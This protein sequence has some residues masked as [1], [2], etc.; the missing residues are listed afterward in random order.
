MAS[1][2]GVYLTCSSDATQFV[3][4]DSRRCCSLPGPLSHENLSH[5]LYFNIVNKY[6]L[7][8]FSTGRSVTLD[9]KVQSPKTNPCRPN[10]RNLVHNRPLLMNK[11]NTYARIPKR[12]HL[13]QRLKLRQQIEYS[14]PGIFG[15]WEKPICCGH[16]QI[17]L[18]NEMFQILWKQYQFFSTAY[19]SK[20]QAY[21]ASNEKR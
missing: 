19:S 10:L 7:P 14:L 1:S 13:I 20:I 9:W 11:N 21:G 16:G 2:F 18:K 4:D 12:I 15:V 6:G 8:S 5:D 17:T 3:R